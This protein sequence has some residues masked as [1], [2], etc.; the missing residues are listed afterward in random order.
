MSHHN[1]PKGSTHYDVF[2][3]VYLKDHQGKLYYFQD[4]LW[5]PS[6]HRDGLNRFKDSKVIKINH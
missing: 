4:G 2:F 6:Q 3:S 5:R 1:I